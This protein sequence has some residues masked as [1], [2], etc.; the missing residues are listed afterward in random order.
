MVL[1]LVEPSPQVFWG[2]DMFI[3]H[4]N[5]QNME[6]TDGR[7]ARQDGTGHVAQELE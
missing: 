1:T 3:H 6:K 2:G 7:T 4:I 5:P